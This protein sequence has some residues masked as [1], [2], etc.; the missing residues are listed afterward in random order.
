VRLLEETVDRILTQGPPVK[1]QHEENNE[2]F[3]FLFK[4]A[5]SHIGRLVGRQN[6]TDR[7]G[8]R[9]WKQKKEATSGLGWPR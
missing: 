9:M 7:E 5:V 2:K 3:S 8:C 1:S 6:L 4:P